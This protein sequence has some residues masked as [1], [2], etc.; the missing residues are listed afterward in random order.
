MDPVFGPG[1]E[2]EGFKQ[3]KQSKIAFF[4]NFFLKKIHEAEFFLKFFFNKNV[5]QEPAQFLAETW[6]FE[7]FVAEV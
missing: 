5:A 1:S 7:Q 4:Q 2:K 6:C 3:K